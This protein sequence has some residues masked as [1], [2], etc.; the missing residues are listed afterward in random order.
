MQNH[1]SRKPQT[2][3][4]LDALQW[5]AGFFDSRHIDA[6]R[7]TAELLLAEVLG[8]NRID[9]YIRHDQPLLD[10]ELAR[11]R[12][13]IRRRAKREPLAYILEKKEFW[14]LE[15]IVAPEVLI[16]RPETE[17]LV[18]AAL[19][20]LPEDADNI[21]RVIDLGTGCGAIV[22]SL[23][24]YRPQNLY[25]GV[26]RSYRAVRV[27]KENA[28]RNDSGQRLHLFVGDWLEPVNSGACGFDM[29]VS[30]PPY[31]PSAQIDSL[32]PEIHN[33]E[34]RLA[35]DGL[36]DGLFAIRAII[37][38]AP[39]HLDSGGF[40]LMEIGYDQKDAVTT[41]CQKTG[42]YRDIEFVRDY[43]GHNRVAVLQKR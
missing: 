1:K 15:F 2:W 4:V 40:L 31:I 27:A 8:L 24:V 12:E 13:V 38:T 42:C 25:F 6:P 10:N 37:D 35:L 11:Y 30:N 29:I 9:L 14:D 34:P 19:E 16:P 23:A 5:T 22:V 28:K 20:R 41:L 17:H 7:L 32:E 33:F 18:E 21:K 36:E 26:D 39:R 3:T 43:G